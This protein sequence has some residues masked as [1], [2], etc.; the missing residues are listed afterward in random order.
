MF[1]TTIFRSVYLFFFLAAFFFAAILFSS[2]TS[3]LFR[4]IQR[5]SAYSIHMY[6]ERRVSC[7]EE[8]E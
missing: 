5:R 7:Q 1:L 6:S 2:Q 4:L 8:S 3:E